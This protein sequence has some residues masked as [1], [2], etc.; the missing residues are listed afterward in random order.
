MN[1]ELSEYLSRVY[2]R[3]AA[4]LEKEIGTLINSTEGRGEFNVSRFL[5]LLRSHMPSVFHFE[6]GVELFDKSGG[7][8]QR[9][10][11]VAYDSIM[12]PTLVS[13]QDA[14]LVLPVDVALAALEV[15]TTLTEGETKRSIRQIAEVKKL[16]F[17]RK[18]VVR[19]EGYGERVYEVKYDTCPPIGVIVAY[20]SGWET[21]ETLE[22]HVISETL[23][24]PRDERWD[25][26]YV[27][28]A[29]FLAV[30]APPDKV[31]SVITASRWPDEEKDVGQNLLNFILTF[32]SML[33]AKQRTI[34]EI[35]FRNDYN[36]GNWLWRLR[37]R[38]FDESG[39]E[40][41]RGL[42]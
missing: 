38:S 24:L 22:K 8:T 29:E 31:A 7:H 10:D 3:S 41:P 39:N 33:R 17:L 27:V 37:G 20:G 25:I 14:N 15:K 2:R 36:L 34:P 30:K 5:Q 28:E 13:I 40:M 1:S 11:I 23:A 12:N 16:D 42:S 6:A 35:D 26:L 32:N 19:A 21:R 4:N 18:K 9:K